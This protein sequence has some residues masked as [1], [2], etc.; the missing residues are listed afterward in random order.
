MATKYLLHFAHEH[1][2]F[3]WAEFTSL[4]TRNN[5]KFKLISSPEHLLSRPY[6]IIELDDKTDSDRLVQSAKGSFLL[7]GLF[8]L[9][10]HACPTIDDLVEEA[11]KSSQFLSR[12][13]AK[14]DQTFRVN[15]ESFGAK[16]NQSTKV[17]WIRRM[18]FMETF[19]SKPDLS[20]PVQTYC[21]FEL[22]KKEL[23]DKCIGKEYYFGRLLTRGNRANIKNFSLKDRAFIANTTMDPLLSLIAANTAMVK[24]NDIVYDPFVGSGSL[25]VAAAYMGAYVLG[26]DIDWLL[27]HGKSR[28]SRKGHKVRQ[29][30]ESVRANMTQY[31]F[32]DRYLDVMVSDVTL[33][34]L[35]QDFT[36]SSIISD[37]PYGI[38][39]CSEKVG[40]KKQTQVRDY[41]VRYPSKTSYG[42]EELLKDLL[43]LSVRHLTV[44]GRLVYFLPITKT[45][46]KFEDFIPSHPCLKLSSFCE[47]SL[48][49]K[50]SRLLVVMEKIRESTDNDKVHIPQIISDMNFRETYFSAS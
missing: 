16:L 12:I 23:A 37:P 15:C 14:P 44:G 13:Y 40:L 47:Q 24:P 19:Q 27:L 3:R 32:A 42:I 31:N 30:G 26:S 18:I 35:R 41:K 43:S 25:L 9:W 11:S 36:I 5:C 21:I 48:T 8:E 7:K 38:R 34:P 17:D 28:P 10:A 2:S 49:A 50:V 22:Y 39:E 46:A 29:A 20:N 1:I 45:G 33:S 4:A 6:I